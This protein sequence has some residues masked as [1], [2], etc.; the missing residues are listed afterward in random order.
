MLHPTAFLAADAGVAAAASLRATRAGRRGVCAAG[1][2]RAHRRR[3]CLVLGPIGGGRRRGR[4]LR[5]LWLL[6]R[7]AVD[8]A[9]ADRSPRRDV[10]LRLRGRL[11]AGGL[12]LVGPSLRLG[13]LLDGRETR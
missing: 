9:R 6:W 8:A 7:R 3:L 10:D 2:R 5:W 13:S 1:R 4:R 12:A 11:T